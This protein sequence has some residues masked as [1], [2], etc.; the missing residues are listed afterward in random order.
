MISI[1]IPTYNEKDNIV[2]L[3]VRLEKTLVD[4]PYEIIFVDD[5]SP[6]GTAGFVRSLKKKD[7]MVIERKGVRGLAGAVVEGVKHARG[8]IVV[9]MDADLSHPPEKIPEMIGKIEGGCEVVVG[10]RLTRGG[11]VV[12][13]PLHRKVI[14]V[15]ATLIAKVAL[16]I[17]CNDPMSGFFAVRKKT[18]ERTDFR[19]SGYKILMNVLADNKTARICEIPYFFAER[20]G[21]K[22]KLGIGEMFRYALDVGQTWLGR[23]K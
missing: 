7:V 16:G 15:G 14:S 23:R 5:D 20:T 22:T 21:G 9:V 2:E 12:D 17:K 19:V 3:V 13:W 6:D 4:A 8:G 11:G 1:V 18:F 10:S